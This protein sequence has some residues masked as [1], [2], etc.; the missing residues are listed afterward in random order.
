[1]SFI[2]LLRLFVKYALLIRCIRRISFPLDRWFMRCRANHRT[3]I[4]VSFKRPFAIMRT[5]DALQFCLSCHWLFCYLRIYCS[6]SPMVF[7][8]AF[9]CDSKCRP[10]FWNA[11]YDM[12]LSIMS[13]R[14]FGHIG[15]VGMCVFELLRAWFSNGI[16]ILTVYSII[17]RYFRI[18]SNY[19]MQIR[20][21]FFKN[22]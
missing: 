21:N 11:R 15:L 19:P 4:A 12:P 2:N 13:E 3:D 8:S 5:C 7:H 10:N 16:Q 17:N 1:M 9:A 22:N 18:F 20:T 14:C 6:R